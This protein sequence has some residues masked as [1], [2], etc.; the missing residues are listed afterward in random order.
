LTADPRVVADAR[1]LDEVSYDEML[2]LA[3][4]GTT[5]LM[6]R[7]VEVGRRFGVP[8]H[9]RSSFHDGPG[10][11]VKEETVEEAIVRAVSH[12]DGEAKITVHGVP[13]QPGVAASLFGRLAKDGIGVDMIVQNVSTDGI[14]DISFTIPKDRS[15]A[16]LEA[17]RAAAAQMEAGGVDLDNDVVRVSVVGA[18]MQSDPRVAA[19]MFAALSDHGVNIEMISTSDIRIS[20]VVKGPRIGDAISALHAEFDPPAV[21]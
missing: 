6:A 3:A 8:I 18:G 5:V 10:T 7:S 12:N 2:E 16:A 21:S 1:K 20:C 17:S 9:V 4:S 11:W 19:R 13:D 15:D 14:T